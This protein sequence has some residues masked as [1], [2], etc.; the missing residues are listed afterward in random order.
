M[1]ER[2]LASLLTKLLGEYVE[3]STFNTE[4]VKLGIWRG[5]KTEGV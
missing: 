3:D 1:F 4:S 5:G 2:A